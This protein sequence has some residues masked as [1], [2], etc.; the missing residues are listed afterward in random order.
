[1]NSP[2]RSDRFVG[3]GH[4]RRIDELAARQHGAFNARQAR[5]AGFDKNAVRRRLLSGS[6]ERLDHLVYAVASSAPTWERRLW[7][8][9]L[10]RPKAVLTHSTAAHL[11]EMRGFTREKPAILVPRGSNTRSETARI[12]ESDEYEKVAVTSIGGFRS[13]TVPETL[14]TLAR[15]TP[16][17]R[18]E[19]AFDDVLIAGRLDL[20]AMLAILDR[21]AGRRPRGIRALREL[22]LSRLPSAPSKNSTYLEAL[23]ERVLHGADVP[24]WTREYRFRLLDH[25]ARVD[26]FVPSWALVIEADGRNWHMKKA[27]FESDRR[28]DNAF[29]AQG[30]EVLRYTFRA[31]Q[32][33]A[34]GCRDEIERV[35]SIRA[36]SGLAWRAPVQRR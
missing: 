7:G 21:E 27:D 33:D 17:R 15:D 18:L 9:L 24:P 29:A 6:W 34:E 32:D 31:L 30:I 35:G 25:V 26:V 13:T 8:T 36:A 16:S 3:V 12:Y 20:N 4:G 1:L 19:S 22:T 28:R 10:S 11:L 23:L 5:E 14:L 2:L